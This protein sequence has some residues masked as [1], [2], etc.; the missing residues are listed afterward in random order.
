MFAI[1]CNSVHLVGLMNMLCIVSHWS[2]SIQSHSVI[3]LIVYGVVINYTA[4]FNSEYIIKQRK[5]LG[6]VL[7]NP[8]QFV[9]QGW[10]KVNNVT[11]LIPLSGKL[12]VS[13]LHSVVFTH[14]MENS[15]HAT[16]S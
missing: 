4:R 16:C 12:T 11:I 6:I 10:A 1:N 5:K 7:A 8:K 14:K 15:L 9:L 2:I 3:P 13:T